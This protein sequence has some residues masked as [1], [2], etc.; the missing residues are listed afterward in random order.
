MPSREEELEKRL[1]ESEKQFWD[2]FFIQYDS[3]LK[4]IRENREAIGK[5]RTEVKV[6]ALKVAFIASAAV[7]ALEFLLKK[8]LH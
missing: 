1:R 4:D 6:L 7:Y 2:R 8:F 3:A 5:I